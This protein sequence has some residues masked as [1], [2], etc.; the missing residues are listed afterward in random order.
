LN[1]GIVN[2]SQDRAYNHDPNNNLQGK[3]RMYMK[4]IQSGCTVVI[5]RL[6]HV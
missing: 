3:I 1:S 4:Q 5:D 2:C 6:K